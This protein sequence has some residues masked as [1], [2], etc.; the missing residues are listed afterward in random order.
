VDAGAQRQSYDV[1][2]EGDAPAAGLEPQRKPVSP[3]GGHGE[4]PSVPARGLERLLVSV[5]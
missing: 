5:G 1:T 4:A 3:D 2:R